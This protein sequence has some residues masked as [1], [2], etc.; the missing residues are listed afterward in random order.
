M[1][2]GLGWKLLS[3]ATLTVFLSATP[4]GSAQTAPDVG[5]RITGYSGGF[6]QMVPIEVPPFHGLEPRLALAYSSYGR[7]GFAGVGWSLA[8]F[9]AIE[10]TSPGRGTPRFD[11]NDIFVLDGQELVPC[12]TGSVSPS[13]TTGGTHSTK[14]E[15]YIRIAFVSSTNSWAVWSKDG[16]KT[17][18]SPAFQT[19]FGTLIWGQTQRVDTRGNT[20][21]YAWALDN[22]DCYPDSVNFGPYRVQLFRETRPDPLSAA[23]ASTSSLRTTRYRLRSVLV[24]SQG[25]PVRAYRLEYSPS[26]ATQSSLLT[27]VRQYGKDVV[28]DGSGVI[29]GGTAL[30]PRT[31]TYQGGSDSRHLTTWTGAEPSEPPPGGMPGDPLVT[32]TGGDGPLT[33]ASG[34]TITLGDPASALAASAVAGS[35]SISLASAAG[36]SVGQEVLLIQMTG[37]SA[38]VYETRTISWISGGTLTLSTVLAHDF[39]SGGSSKTQAIRIRHYTTVTVASGGVLTASP[40]NG[41]IGGVLFFRA[42][43]AVTVAAGGTMTVAGRG[44]AGGAGGTAS[45]VMSNGTSGGTGGPGDAVNQH[46]PVIPE[47]GQVGWCDSCDYP[48]CQEISGYPGGAAQ[49][50]GGT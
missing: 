44:F 31:F 5:E 23:A 13:C 46:C 18:L 49:T 42:T 22:G 29:S 25:A 27:S 12:A 8:G 17:T 38:G 35:S 28:I 15:S 37:P 14:V 30:P 32:G 47:V 40:W 20:A 43:G 3:V 34:Q 2:E 33:V 4:R 39:S 1:C 7:N 50:G 21:T 45:T 24:R 26:L 10:R 19:P 41:S 6:S 16:S 9:S 36:F 11:S 48:I